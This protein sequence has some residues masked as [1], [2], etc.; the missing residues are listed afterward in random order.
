MRTAPTA[1]GL[2]PL[3]LA[4]ALV[5]GG[6]LPPEHVHPAGIEGRAHSI[7]HRHAPEP[8]SSR[9]VATTAVTAHGNHHRAV[10]L[11][12]VYTSMVRVVPPA[13]GV[14][15][16]ATLPASSAGTAERVHVGD[17]HGA[18]GPPRATDSPRAPPAAA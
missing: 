9:R 13:P 16:A 12:A 2:V 6:A 5:L 15:V 4:C 17:V 18:H 1:A 8:S 3:M 7:V 11:R 14:A 10:F